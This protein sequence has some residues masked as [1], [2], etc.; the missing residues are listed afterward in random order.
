MVPE[1]GLRSG[2]EGRDPSSWGAP[3]VP[4]S[5]PLT[6]K[7]GERQG[8]QAWPGEE[9]T[10]ASSR[11][12]CRGSSLDT[13]WEARGKKAGRLGAAAGQAPR[14][15]EPRF[16]PRQWSP[17]NPRWPGT[18]VR[19]GGSGRCLGA[20]N[21]GEET[22]VQRSEVRPTPFSQWAPS[23]APQTEPTPTG[24]TA[25]SPTSYARSKYLKTCI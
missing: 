19:K 15:S 8:D 21:P 2:M 11:N 4:G 22:E 14:R 10:G 23:S 16:P 7:R 6:T 18:T 13:K 9:E 5:L 17:S 12:E 24:Q 1:T 20:Q 25:Q 3:R